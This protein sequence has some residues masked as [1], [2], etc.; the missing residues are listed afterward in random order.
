MKPAT[1]LWIVLLFIGSLGAQPGQAQQ[2]QSD[3]LPLDSLQ[4]TSTQPVDTLSLN[5]VQLTAVARAFLAIEDMRQEYQMR[6]G[7]GQKDSSV[8]DP[9]AAFQQAA[10]QT[11]QAESLTVSRY[12]QVLALARRDS[13]L[14][15]R[16]VRQITNLRKKPE[17]D[18]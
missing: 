14:R 4:Q 6:Y 13:A 2:P 17:K 7:T 12:Q 9:Y 10:H 8:V 3:N 1:H 5:D 16:L 18:S 15:R 11:V